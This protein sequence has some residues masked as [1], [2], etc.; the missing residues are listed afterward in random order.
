MSIESFGQHPRETKERRNLEFYRN[1][2]DTLQE[3]ARQENKSLCEI[4]ERISQEENIETRRR[5]MSWL[6][7]LLITTTIAFNVALTS[8]QNRALAQST[9]EQKVVYI[10]GKEEIERFEKERLTHYLQL[11]R[12]IEEEKIKEKL[13]F[14]RKLYG[15]ALDG[16]LSLHKI[17]QT[18]ELLEKVEKGLTENDPNIL[19]DKDFPLGATYGSFLSNYFK[20]HWVVL[21]KEEKLQ[22]SRKDII[23]QGFEKLPGFSNEEIKRVLEKIYPP[24]WLLGSTREITYVDEIV[25]IDETFVKGGHTRSYGFSALAEEDIRAP[26][27]VF[28]IPGGYTKEILYLILHHELA[29]NND[30]QNSLLLSNQERINFLYEVT[31]RYLNPDSFKSD[32]VQSIKIEGDEKAELYLK[33]TEFW[34][35]IVAA[36]FLNRDEFKK[37]Y[38]ED[39]KLVER[40]FNRINDITQEQERAESR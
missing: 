30:W 16:F 31:L 32:Y 28:N 15:H 17:N 6:Q 27:V 13:E 26:I 8:L 29:H 25:R 11:K 10:L 4:R 18:L 38:P 3:L 24:Q 9:P 35:E 7:L 33:V 22:R 12:I 37:N 39:A 34:A 21:S 19:V 40:W 5:K 14:L 2:V 23:V 20:N 36:Y 1:K